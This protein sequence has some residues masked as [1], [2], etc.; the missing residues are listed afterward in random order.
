MIFGKKSIRSLFFY[1]GF[2]FILKTGLLAGQTD[3]LDAY[4]SGPI[5]LEQDPEFG[6]NTDWN[7]LFYHRF[8]D[9]TVAPDGSLFIAS[10]RQHTIFKF[11]PNGN[12][13][14]SFGRE[15]QGPGDFYMPG[16]L[17][18][19]DEKLLVVGENASSQRISFF[20]LEGN[21]KKVLKTSRPPYSPVALRDGKIA[22]I[23]HSYRG[24]G[25]SDRKRIESVLIRDINTDQET[26]VAEFTFNMT[27]ILVGPGSLG[28]GDATSGE[29]LIAS[30]HEGNLIVGNSRFPSFDVFS[31][32]GAKISTLQ[33]NME[34]IPVTKRLISEYKE[35]HINQ[36]SQESPISKD[37]TQDMV[38]QL[39]KASWDHMFGEHLPLYREII[40]DAEGYLLVFRRTDCLGDC[41]IFFQVY[42]P[43]GKFI[44]ET[45]LV[46]GSFRLAV[47]PRIRNM[48]F[49]SQGLIAMVEVKDAEE[50][51]LRVIKVAY[52]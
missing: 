27:S 31:P 16:D 36:F 46:E 33:L 1:I 15:G 20:D 39:K 9:L 37:Q 47:N 13:V 48:C 7:S 34:Q 45:E 30:S 18:I 41:P 14:K 11:D 17:S 25:P 8:C 24:D 40:V 44:C 29:F 19:L 5:H 43:E 35:Y 49:T 2:F 23:I 21:F 22:Y 4:K 32:E 10:S 42:S 51:E 50:F 3:L 38:K 12:L 6:K 52:Q 26:K 28:F